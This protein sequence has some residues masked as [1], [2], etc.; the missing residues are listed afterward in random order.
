MDFNAD[1]NEISYIEYGTLLSS[2]NLR[3]IQIKYDEK[4][5]IVADYNGNYWKVVANL[6]TFTAI[7][8]RV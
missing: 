1:V 3:I 6:S 2:N 7:L 5:V 8:T 4:H